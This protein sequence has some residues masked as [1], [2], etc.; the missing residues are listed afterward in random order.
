M[1]KLKS[2]TVA[3]SD[4]FRAQQP[5]ATKAAAI[6][7]RCGARL[8]LLNTFMLP[9]PMPGLPMGDSQA[10]LDA[11]ARL[12]KRHLRKLAQTLERKMGIKIRCEVHWDH[13][14]HAA[15]VRHVL[16]KKP[17]LLVADSHRHNR[18]VRM[19]LA[20]TDWELIRNCP[21]PLLFV[22]SAKLPV[23]PK[24]LVALDPTHSH[25]KPSRLDAHLLSAAN[26]VAHGIG[27]QVGAAHAYVK[28]NKVVFSPTVGPLSIPLSPGESLTHFARIKESI[29]KVADRYS[30]A[31]QSRHIKTGLPSDV[32]VHLASALKT[33][34]LVMGAVSRGA[35]DR[36]FIGST[37]ERVI[38]HVECDVLVIKPTGF[39]TSI[40]RGRPAL[41]S[42]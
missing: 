35:L 12:R 33:N 9:Q 20:N 40:A 21:C 16:E 2:I 19:V 42:R 41:P 15:I 5:A 14:P 34:V 3:I 24:L 29:D 22:R 38:D 1:K 39:R 18:L 31:Q 32:L 27:G 23:K 7:Q 28:P 26:I 17:D 6:A 36:L 13:P 11:T 4:L 37:A 8:T 25:A 30:V 10:M